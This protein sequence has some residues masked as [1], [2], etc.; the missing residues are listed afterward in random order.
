MPGTPRQ[1]DQQQQRIRQLPALSPHGQLQ[2]REY[3]RRRLAHAN[4]ALEGSTLNES[5]TRLVLEQGLAIGGKPLRDHLLVLG[6]SE[7][8]NMLYYLARLGTIEEKA[9]QAL[10]QLYYYRVDA[11]QA[12]RYRRDN[13]IITETVFMPPTPPQLAATMQ[14]LIEHIAAKKSALSTLAFASW[15]HLRLVN[16]HPFGAGN[17]VVAR[18]IMNLALMQAH[19][20]ITLIL[21]QHRS[22]YM[23]AI[24]A[25]NHNDEQPFTTFLAARVEEAQH[26]YLRQIAG[27][28]GEPDAPS[29]SIR[30]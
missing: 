17:G 4:N 19:Y 27:L 28:N 15:L 22:D 20:P 11:E 18:L 1:I 23:A 7:A 8:F 21:P 6:H 14:E 30:E 25:G 9:L 24:N 29:V 12:G 3:Y 5:E 2:L 26:D 16:I 10:H 13:L